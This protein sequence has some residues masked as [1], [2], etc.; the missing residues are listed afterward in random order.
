MAYSGFSTVSSNSQKK[1]ILTGHQLIIQDLTNA[2]MTRRGER[3]MLPDYGCIIWEKLFEN[4]TQ[5]D[6]DEISANISS[7]VNN[8]P[9]VV[10]T[11]LDISP[12]NNTITVTIEIQY[13]NTDETDT[14]ILNYNSEIS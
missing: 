5:T 14:I 4:I 10:L 2:L 11:S 6:V 13:V 8:D 3:L 12:I 1:F 7:I 9:R